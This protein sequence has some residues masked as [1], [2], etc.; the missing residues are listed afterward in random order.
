L[1]LCVSASLVVSL[2]AEMA[3]RSWDS[4]KA[5]PGKSEAQVH[6]IAAESVWGQCGPGK[7]VESWK[8]RA[9]PQVKHRLEKLGSLPLS[10]SRSAQGQKGPAQRVGRLEEGVRASCYRLTQPTGLAPTGL[11]LPSKFR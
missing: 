5:A 2:Q 8:L 10:E 3:L 11:E 1:L 4:S 7:P 6:Q 9:A